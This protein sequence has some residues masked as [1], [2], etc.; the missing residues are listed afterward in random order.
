MKEYNTFKEFK[1]KGDEIFNV[2]A[3]NSAK[4]IEHHRIRQTKEDQPFSW[5]ELEKELYNLDSGYYI[6]QDLKI[7]QITKRELIKKKLH[8]NK[9]ILALNEYSFTEVQVIYFSND[10]ISIKF[11]NYLNNDVTE[12]LKKDS[13]ASI[14]FDE[15]IITTKKSSTPCEPGLIFIGDLTIQKWISEYLELPRVR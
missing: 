10:G 1:E 3:K 8:K 12:R 11:K 2:L 15:Y 14:D 5:S 6:P 7:V 9:D 4:R 13:C